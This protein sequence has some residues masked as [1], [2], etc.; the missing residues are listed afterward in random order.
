MLRIFENWLQNMALAFCK[1][2]YTMKKIR[3]E[4]ENIRAED[5]LLR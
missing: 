2:H 5:S 4:G 3:N 1:S